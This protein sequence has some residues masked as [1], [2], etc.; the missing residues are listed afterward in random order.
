MQY[1]I[2]YDISDDTRRSRAAACLL[3]FGSRIQESVFVANLDDQLAARMCERL[4]KVV[5]ESEDK[6]HIFLLC[7][8]CEG[9]TWVY[10]QGEVP[11]DREFYII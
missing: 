1:V 8:A 5:K 4:Q 10:G 7:A 6:V 2:C 9:K 11:Q 3:D